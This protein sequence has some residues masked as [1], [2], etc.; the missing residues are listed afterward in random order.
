MEFPTYFI[1]G[2]QNDCPPGNVAGE[3]ACLKLN[4][5]FMR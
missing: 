3:S 2:K 1:G 4:G 5:A